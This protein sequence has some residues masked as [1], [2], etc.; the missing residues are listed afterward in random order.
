MG[1][2]GSGGHNRKSARVKELEGNRGHRPI[3]EE[4]VV[5]LP[6]T[7]PRCPKTLDKIAKGVWR[8]I[9]HEMVKAGTI[10]LV[11]RYLLA[12][13]CSACSV[14]LRAKGDMALFWDESN[15]QSSCEECHRLKSASEDGAFGNP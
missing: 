2:R 11:D 13:Y 12:S 9:V 6:V 15:W 10:T 4:A 3:G 8:E 7:R 5:K 14:Y 1:G